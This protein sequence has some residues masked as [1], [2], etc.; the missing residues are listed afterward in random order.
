MR[1]ATPLPPLPGFV[2]AALFALILLPAVA[3]ADGFIVIREPSTTVPIR[4]HFQFAPLGVTYHRVTVDIKDQVATTT[5]DQEF[6]NPNPQR[7]EGTYLFPL[8]AGAHVDKFSMDVNGKM[9]DAE[10]LDAAKARSIYE[11]IVR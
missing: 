7:M 9:T 6:H 3:R 11:E 2:T 4:G 10:L 8:P 1:R 5:V